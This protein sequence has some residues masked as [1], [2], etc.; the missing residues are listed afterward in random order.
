MI[1][2]FSFVAFGLLAGFAYLAH[3]RKRVN[4]SYGLGFLAISFGLDGIKG[5]LD[6]SLSGLQTFLDVVRSVAIGAGL[7]FL[8]YV[9]AIEG[10][11]YYVRRRHPLQVD[12]EVE[13][14]T[15]APVRSV[16]YRHAP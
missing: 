1:F 5:I 13:A 8:G 9:A 11:R 6:P 12:D 14:Q 3:L 4:I 15:T 10:W 16:P 7:S 2:A